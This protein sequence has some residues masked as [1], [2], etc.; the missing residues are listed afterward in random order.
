MQPCSKLA[1]FSIR[2]LAYG[3]IHITPDNII[4]RYLYHIT[5]TGVTGCPV[6][7][8]YPDISIWLIFQRFTCCSTVGRIQNNILANTGYGFN[9][10]LTPGN[11]FPNTGARCITGSATIIDDNTN[12]RSGQI[13]NPLNVFRLP[14]FT[15]KILLR[16]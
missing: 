5:D 13:V 1:G 16:R 2:I 14:F 10:P 12:T 4:R 3:N 11:I 8:G 9:I 7:P 15:S 6:S